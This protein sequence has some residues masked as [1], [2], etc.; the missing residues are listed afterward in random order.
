MP[1]VVKSLKYINVGGAGTGKAKAHVRYIQHRPGE[2][3]DVAASGTR[4]FFDG[5]R[6]RVER[7]EINEAIEKQ[8]DGVAIHKLVLSPGVSGVDLKNYTREM[9]TEFERSKGQKLDWYG[10]VHQNTDHDHV[11]VVI[12]GRDKE[13]HRV[14]ID[15][16]DHDLLRSRGD[17]Y[18][19][20]EHGIERELEKELVVAEKVLEERGPARDE[21]RLSKLFGKGA[22]GREQPRDVQSEKWDRKRAIEALPDREKIVLKGKT[23]CRFSS[24]KDLKQLD[25]HL[26]AHK[27]D[28]IKRSQYAM[29]RRWLEEKERN[30]EDCHTRWSKEELQKK[31]KRAGRDWNK[32]EA[33]R[34]LQDRELI[35]V[36]GK[37]Y[38]KFNSSKELLELDSQ[39]QNNYEDRIEKSQY[40][41]LKGWIK[42]KRERGEDCYENQ[43][44]KSFERNEKQYLQPLDEAARN[45]LK[46]DDG[47]I[48]RYLTKEQYE[49]HGRALDFHAIYANNIAKQRLM[50]AAAR[51]PELEATYERDLAELKSF[52]SDIFAEMETIDLDKLFGCGEWDK[53]IDRSFDVGADTDKALDLSS[54]ATDDHLDGI[55][56]TVDPFQE[57]KPEH[58]RIVVEQTQ[59][60]DDEKDN[61]ENKADDDRTEKQDEREDSLTGRQKTPGQD[62]SE[63]QE[64][65]T[66]SL[67]RVNAEN[68]ARIVRELDAQAQIKRRRDKDEKDR[69][70]DEHER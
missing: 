29:M 46:L 5:S 28:R 64:Q 33:V 25:E 27:E 22:G 68:A 40:A 21:D 65:G 26:K 35:V 38:S 69:D 67:A 52:S 24:S 23:Y 62:D 2:D 66:D 44:K 53:D 1:A 51:H 56:G 13:N 48:G 63:E 58:G 54:I 10:T 9:M 12:M 45:A 61:L 39:L 16:N 59:N 32:E 19:E 36:R 15:R 3:R 55:E 60:L 8:K 37:T 18:L 11:H 43:S 70:D 6:E 47:L 7:A 49:T 30:G 14:R 42:D 57:E 20:R 4:D 31:N 41:M 17:R 50:E 34:N